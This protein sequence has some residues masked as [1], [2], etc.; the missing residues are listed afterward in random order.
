MSQAIIQLL[1]FKLNP[2][3]KYFAYLWL[4][5]NKSLAVDSFSCLFKYLFITRYNC[6]CFISMFACAWVVLKRATFCGNNCEN[7]RII[8]RII[9]EFKKN[10]RKE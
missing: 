1:L 10:F 7:V 2:T 3:I 8:L 5:L 4:Q 6:L 9:G